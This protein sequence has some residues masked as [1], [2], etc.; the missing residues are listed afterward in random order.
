MLGSRPPHN[1]ALSIGRGGLPKATVTHVASGA[2]VDVYLHGGCLTS[3]RTPS[4][5]DALFVSSAAVWDGVKPIRG[6][7]PICWPQFGAQGPLPQHGFARTEAWTLEAAGD[8]C[9]TL[10]LRD[11]ER[12]RALWPHAFRLR[13]RIQFDASQLVTHLDVENPAGAPA[14]FAFEALQHTYLATGAPNAFGDVRVCGLQGAK[15][16]SKPHAN[17]AFTDEA[18]AIALGGEVDRIYCNTP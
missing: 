7:I 3:W 11:N 13:L 2:A 9:A 16:L 14:P 15:Y 18:A 17:A 4:G 5:Q 12:T 8:G 10:S 1:M 6:G